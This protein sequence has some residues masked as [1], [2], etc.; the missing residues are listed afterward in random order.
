MKLFHHNHEQTQAL[1]GLLRDVAQKLVGITFNNPAEDHAMIR[2]HAS[3]KGKME[4]LQELLQDDFE[5]KQPT[6]QTGE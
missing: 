1:L 2:Y 3:L 4:L 5:V 6:Q